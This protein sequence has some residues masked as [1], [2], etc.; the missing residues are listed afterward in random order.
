[1]KARPQV[2]V[3][4]LGV[5][6]VAIAA[7]SFFGAHP[8]EEASASASWVQPVL[9]KDVQSQGSSLDYFHVGAVNAWNFQGA[10]NAKLSNHVLTVGSQWAQTDADGGAAQVTGIEFG[11]YPSPTPSATCSPEGRMI[12]TTATGV[13]KSLLYECCKASG[14]ATPKWSLG[15]CQ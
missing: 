7:L 9:L 5:F 2:Y 14:S 8:E 11:S 4:L 10:G 12:T 15:I 13:Q 6:S 3:M 1:M